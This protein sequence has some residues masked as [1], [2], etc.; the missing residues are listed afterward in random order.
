MRLHDNQ[1]RLLFS[2]LKM[3]CA[4]CQ[5]LCCIAYCF[6]KSDGF[7]ENKL[8][9]QA[10]SHL[11]H[12][13]QCDIHAQLATMNLH[14]CMAYDCFGAG[15]RVSALMNQGN[16]GQHLEAFRKA[17][18]LHQMEW[19]LIEAATLVAAKS[20]WFKIEAQISRLEAQMQ[21]LDLCFNAPI[22]QLRNEANQLL[23]QA[24]QLVQQDNPIQRD[25]SMKLL[26]AK[27]FKN[28]SFF[29]VNFLAA[30]LRDADFSGADLRDALFLTQAQIN[31]AK[32]NHQTQ[33]PSWLIRP[34]SWKV[35]SK[36]K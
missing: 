19:Y 5:G 17:V 36:E 10:C 7:P 13:Y 20:L 21:S 18:Q 32:G 9:E 28:Q 25:L 6:F 11:M 23:K 22:K 16:Q 2:S 4:K 3:D 33:L 34:Q 29:A 12:T 26:M 35:Q 8:P 30:D 27:N 1:R 24:W 14:G 31:S 15:Q